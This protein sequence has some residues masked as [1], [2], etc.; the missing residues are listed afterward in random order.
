MRFKYKEMSMVSE[1]LVDLTRKIMN[2][3][4]LSNNAI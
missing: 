3:V 2:V 4:D 1:G